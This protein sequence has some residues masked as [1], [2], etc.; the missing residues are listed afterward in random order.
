MEY[1]KF[2][3][4]DPH[5]FKMK[6]G[7]LDE[8]KRI[9]SFLSPRRRTFNH[10][11]FNNFLNRKYNNVNGVQLNDTVLLK[12]NTNYFATNTDTSGCESS[13]RSGVLVKLNQSDKLILT[14]LIEQNNLQFNWNQEKNKS[15]HYQI[16]D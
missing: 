5:Q 4:G 11:S 7:K 8:T 16:S 1:H 9:K 2:I 10:S 13:D 14:S 3:F 12:H 6:N 15:I